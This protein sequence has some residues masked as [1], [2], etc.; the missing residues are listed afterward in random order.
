MRPTKLDKKVSRRALSR[1]VTDSKILKLLLVEDDLDDEQLL[2]EALIEIEENRL[3]CNW[4]TSTIV[5]VEQLSDA[6]DCLRQGS[7]DAILLNLSLPD[8]PALLDTF[9]EISAAVKGAPIVILADEDDP[10]L[11]NRLLR[12]GAQDILIKSELEC[13]LLARSVRHSIERQRRAQ[14]LGA[15]PFVDDLTGVLTPQG[16]VTIAEHY[17]QLSRR[18]RTDLLLASLEISAPPANTQEDRE[19]RELLLAHAGE[20]LRGAFE[21][22]ALIGRLERS[23]FSVITAGLTSTTAKALL[24][25]CATVIEAEGC[26]G[27][28]QIVRARFSVGLLSSQESLDDLVAFCSGNGET[29]EGKRSFR[30]E[31]SGNGLPSVIGA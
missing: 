20:V 1:R 28:R 22:P 24:D 4:R 31:A 16:F 17:A 23:R 8:S 3:W 15:S 10:H 21:P 13:A 26:R 27:G 30:A 9:L 6:L 19:A 18:S 12:E 29:G 2:C 7:F 5:Q 25:R 11:A 14:A